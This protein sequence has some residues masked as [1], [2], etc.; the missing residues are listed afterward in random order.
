M[1]FFNLQDKE[2]CD[3]VIRQLYG[4][5]GEAIKSSIARY[6]PPEI[7]REDPEDKKE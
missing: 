3:F 7:L 6:L 5:K 1:Y 2:Y 4:E